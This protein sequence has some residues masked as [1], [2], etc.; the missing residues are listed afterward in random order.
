MKIKEREQDKKRAYQVMYSIYTKAKTT[1]GMY[2]AL[3]NQTDWLQNMIEC[4]FTEQEAYNEFEKMIKEEI[5]F[6]KCDDGFAILMDC[7][8]A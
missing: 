6:E 3:L 5:W 7:P 8:G 2:R 1:K 4:D